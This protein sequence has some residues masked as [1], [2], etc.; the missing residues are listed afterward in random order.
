MEHTF[1]NFEFMQGFHPYSKEVH[2]QLPRGTAASSYPATSN[3]LN[4]GEEPVDLAD[5]LAISSSNSINVKQEL[6]QS[7]TPTYTDSSL[8]YTQPSF[9]ISSGIS[10]RQVILAGRMDQMNLAQGVETVVEQVYVSEGQ[11]QEGGS[12][13]G[14]MP[15]AR[16]S[17]VMVGKKLIDKSSDEY[18]RRRERNNVAVRR[19]R[20]KTRHKREETERR[21]V[22]LEEENKKLREKLTLLNKEINVLKSLFSSVGVPPSSNTSATTTTTTATE[23]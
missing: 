21:V 22:E 5:F 7:P 1:G 3:Y 12:T 8:Q 18:R 14:K 20:D 17:Q 2:S 4:S 10:P 6:Y 23:L 19:S 13:P 11:Q 15:R 16:P 9:G